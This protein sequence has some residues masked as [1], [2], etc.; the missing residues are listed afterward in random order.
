MFTEVARVLVFPMTRVEVGSA[1]APCTSCK[2]HESVADAAPFQK[3]ADKDI[4]GE[5]KL[6][7]FVAGVL[8]TKLNP[9]VTLELVMEKFLVPSANVVFPVGLNVVVPHAP[10][11][12]SVTVPVNVGDASGAAPVICATV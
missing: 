1:P 8:C 5:L 4:T 7:T 2:V 11:F 10:T 9:S 6:A 12:G 3:L